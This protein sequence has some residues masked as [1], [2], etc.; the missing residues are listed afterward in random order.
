MQVCNAFGRIHRS[1]LSSSHLL[2]PSLGDILCTLEQNIL[3]MSAKPK[4]LVVPLN[5]PWSMDYV[6]WEK[7]VG[8][9][10]ANLPT[11]LQLCLSSVYTHQEICYLV[12]IDLSF[13]I[14][15]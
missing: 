5:F 9:L 1:F 12:G 8:L 3:V 13:S 7:R 4:W 10:S 2:G 15:W 11:P 14:Y 6:H